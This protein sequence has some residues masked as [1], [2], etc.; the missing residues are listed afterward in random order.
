VKTI[1]D[2][3]NS[4]CFPCPNCWSKTLNQEVI[5]NRTAKS[6]EPC[7][8][9][10]EELEVLDAPATLRPPN[11]VHLQTDFL[12]Y[13]AHPGWPQRQ[14]SDPLKHGLAKWNPA[15][16]GN[17]RPSLSLLPQRQSIF[18]VLSDWGSDYDNVGSIRLGNRSPSNPQ[19]VM[20]GWSETDGSPRKTELAI[21]SGT[22]MVLKPGTVMAMQQAKK[23]NHFILINLDI[24]LQEV[25]KTILS[26]NS[27]G[28]ELPVSYNESENIRPRLISASRMAKTV[29]ENLGGKFNIA[30]QGLTFSTGPVNSKLCFK[31]SVC[32]LQLLQR[33]FSLN[34][35]GKCAGMGALG[36]HSL[37]AST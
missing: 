23:R 12:H 28:V 8:A 7:T 21:E 22:M 20:S 16:R 4:M 34:Q 3:A 18:T 31:M 24:T 27:G 15:L 30:T 35:G 11:M 10:R 14:L 33:M 6:E 19:S 32:D 13:S 37:I 25:V 9:A 17:P 29:R 26:K 2:I 1:Y 36:K 5:S